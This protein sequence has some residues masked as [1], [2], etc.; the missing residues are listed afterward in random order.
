MTYRK[1]LRSLARPAPPEI[2]TRA[3][4]TTN[5]IHNINWGIGSSIRRRKGSAHRTHLCPTNASDVSS[6][7]YASALM[8]STKR[9]SFVA[10]L[11]EAPR[12]RT[13]QAS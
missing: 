11:E 1:Y 9:D 8:V 2:P 7:R 5:K 3:N 10:F 13:G 6:K 4:E 12:K